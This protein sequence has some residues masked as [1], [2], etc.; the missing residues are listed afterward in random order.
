MV[1]IAAG[2][3]LA[4]GVI[5]FT[6]KD[7]FG[8]RWIRVQGADRPFELSGLRPGTYRVEADSMQFYVKGVK[9]AGKIESPNEVILSP[10]MNR[11]TVVVA[12]DHARVFGIVR[13]APETDQPLPQGRIALRGDRGTYSVQADQAGSFL[14][15]RVIPGEYRVCAWTNLAPERVEDEMSWKQAGCQLRTISIGPSSQIQINLRA[16]P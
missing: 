15:T 1:E 4:D 13:G 6:S 7:G 11:L 10:G 14:F 2:A 9:T 8:Y 3:P 12:A 5:R 16:A